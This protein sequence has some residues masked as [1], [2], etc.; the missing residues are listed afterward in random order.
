MND[1]SG[2][3]VVTVRQHR[4]RR[5]VDE[6]AAVRVFAYMPAQKK[7]VRH[8]RQTKEVVKALIPRHLI[9]WIDDEVDYHTTRNTADVVGYLR[10]PDQ[11]GVLK[12]W[13]IPTEQVLELNLYEQMGEFDVTPYRS[14]L[15]VG[16]AVEA[17]CGKWQGHRMT[18]N[19]IKPDHR[20]SVTMTLFNSK[21]SQPFEMDVRHLRAA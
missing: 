20:A 1:I 5:V 15:Q 14:E 18:L 13:R 3:Y 8:A 10:L 19:A 6:L 12:A 16:Q 17:I 21:P 2:F 4:E 7:L 11:Y 9:V